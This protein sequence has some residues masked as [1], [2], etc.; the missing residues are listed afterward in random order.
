MN[1]TH[2]VGRLHKERQ[3]LQQQIGELFSFITKQREEV[4]SFVALFLF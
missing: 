3:A 4:V 1:M 2:E